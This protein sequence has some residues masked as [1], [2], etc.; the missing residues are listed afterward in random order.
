VDQ[1][2]LASFC[3]LVA[4]EGVYPAR[5]GRTTLGLA[6]GLEYSREKRHFFE[7]ANQFRSTM[8]L[9]AHPQ[10][11]RP[12]SIVCLLEPRQSNGVR[13][14]KLTK[15]IGKAWHQRMNE[16]VMNWRILIN[17]MGHAGDMPRI[18]CCR[19]WKH[20]GDEAQRISRH[21]FEEADK[22]GDGR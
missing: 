19:I 8:I 13:K 6:Q 22:S 3:N 16:I 17:N 11:A 20:W 2:A 12:I 21:D 14:G 18:S 1:N 7:I 4:V 9:L 15:T 5:F 10:F